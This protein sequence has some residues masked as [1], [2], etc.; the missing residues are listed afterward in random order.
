MIV[1]FADYVREYLIADSA[2]AIEY[3]TG[4]V[5]PDLVAPIKSSRRRSTVRKDLFALFLG[6]LNKKEKMSVIEIDSEELPEN[7]RWQGMTRYV[8]LPLKSKTGTV[9]GVL[10]ALYDANRPEDLDVAAHTLTFRKLSKAV[11]RHMEV[12]RGEREKK[13]S[14]KM[15]IALSRFIAGNFSPDKVE[16]TKPS[17]GSVQ[18][19]TDAQEMERMDE[20]RIEVGKVRNEKEFERWKSRDAKRSEQAKMDLASSPTGGDVSPEVRMI[21]P[22]ENGPSYFDERPQPATSP[23]STKSAEFTGMYGLPFKTPDRSPPCL[24]R[25]SSSDDSSSD[26][27][28]SSFL[29]R[30]PLFSPDAQSKG[31][32]ED[33]PVVPT[34][35]PSTVGS[36]TAPLGSTPINLAEAHR[37]LFMRAS[38]LMYQAMDVDGVAFINAD[39]EGLADFALPSQPE[40]RI[41]SPARA[42]PVGHVSSDTHKSKQVRDDRSEEMR[43]RS[44]VLGF[45]DGHPVDSRGPQV[46]KLTEDELTMLTESWPRGCVFAYS[47]DPTRPVIGFSVNR[48]GASSE[49]ELDHAME[50]NP[51]VVAILRR[52]LPKSQSV[53]FL[54]LY[55]FVGKVFAVGFAWTSSSVRIF[56]GDVEGDFMAAFCDSIMSEVSRL[57]VVS[58]EL[59]RV[60]DEARFTTDIFQRMWQ[61]QISSR[62]CRMN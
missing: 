2:S 16:L 25:E 31:T 36:D 32:P 9:I 53:V 21:T 8:G 28:D 38:Q 11:M 50:Q 61:S 48:A 62:Q 33:P 20:T 6:R 18:M 15:E 49:S 4:I 47:K 51:E 17:E 44:G 60:R 29:T 3:Y 26:H 1:V 55:D 34:H 56:R 37:A 30:K 57:H 10:C 19:E 42:R 13:K 35:K 5:Q 46:A 40:I 12:V 14:R 52:F 39:L 43:E 7:A 22:A 24:P 59:F 27:F 54:P 45:F 41:P 58:G 23:P